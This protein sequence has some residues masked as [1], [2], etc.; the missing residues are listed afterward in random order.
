M[1]NTVMTTTALP[2]G[3][4][5]TVSEAGPTSVTVQNL[6]PA[7]DLLIRIGAVTES[8]GLDEAADVL[9]PF[10]FRELTIDATDVIIARPVSGDGRINVRA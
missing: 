5:T 8:D 4:W 2:A 1:A 10:E 6:S 3:E 9:R 7:T